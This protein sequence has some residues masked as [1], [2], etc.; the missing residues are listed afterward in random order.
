M[1]SRMR[2]GHGSRSWTLI[3]VRSEVGRPSKQGCLAQ[4][5]AT[6]TQKFCEVAKCVGRRYLWIPPRARAS[7][8]QAGGASRV[9]GGFGER[10]FERHPTARQHAAICRPV[11]RGS[12]RRSAAQRPPARRRAAVPHIDRRHQDDWPQL[13]AHFCLDRDQR[14]AGRRLGH[15]H[16]LR[17]HLRLHSER[18]SQPSRAEQGHGHGPRL[19]GERA[20]HRGI[21]VPSLAHDGDAGAESGRAAAAAARVA[22]CI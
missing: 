11:R 19:P 12:A 22:A 16:G 5:S 1:S 10:P 18:P 14:V 20:E 4:S 8:Q 6:R 9:A 13:E 21:R 15:H 2:C 17:P 7:A 3:S